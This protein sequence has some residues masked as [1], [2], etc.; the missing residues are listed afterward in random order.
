MQQTKTRLT[1]SQLIKAVVYIIFLPVLTLFLSGDWTWTE[2]WLYGG[3]FILLYGTIAFYLYAKDPALLAERFQRKQHENQAG[4]DKYLVS[5]IAVLYITWAVLIP[6]DAQRYHW[7]PSFPLWIKITGCI[8]LLL[9]FFFYFRSFT[10]NTFLSTVVRVQ[11]D[12]KQQ[13]V[14]TGVYGFVRHP[15]YLGSIL[16]FLGVPLLTGSVYGLATGIVVSLLYT[17][18]IIEEEKVLAKDL[19]GYKDYQQKIR[20]RLIP[21]VW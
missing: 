16:N 18:R 19:E 7:S 14:S 9:S 4:W 5:L 11:T 20:Y 2:G 21:K 8:A 13:V 12:R 1:A 17:Y 15:M 10:D 3:W 6:L